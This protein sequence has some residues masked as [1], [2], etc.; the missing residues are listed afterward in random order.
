MNEVEPTLPEA[1]DDPVGT[2]P[3]DAIRHF[4]A[5]GNERWSARQLWMLL[6]YSTWQKFENALDRARQSLI[7]TGLSVED[8]FTRSVKNPS[9]RGGRP[10]TDYELTRYA[11]YVTVMNAD[12]NMPRVAEAQAY[13]AIQTRRAEVAERENVRFMIP[14]TMADALRLAADEYERAELASE[15]ARMLNAQIEHQAPKVAKAEAHS[16]SDS[17]IHRQA[18]AREVQQWGT[19][20]GVP[21]LQ[22]Q[23]HELLRR[24]GMLVGGARSDRNHA[25][26]QAVSSGWARTHKDVTKDGHAYATTYLLPRGQDIAWKWITEHVAAHGN[27]S[28]ERNVA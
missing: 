28:M 23:V 1:P 9:A 17:S 4:D 15:Q 14:R 6:D 13:F 7:N 21:V 11:A 19:T 5:D 24:K 25:T 3:F 22:E 18:F 2:S 16:T 27:L 10:A 12:P 20:I 8:H 26:A